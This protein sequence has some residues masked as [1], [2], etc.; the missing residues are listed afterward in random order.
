MPYSIHL[1]R[2]NE[3]SSFSLVRS[4]AMKFHLSKFTTKK[5]PNSSDQSQEDL[6]TQQPFA[7][8]K[9]FS[10][11]SLGVFLIASLVLVLSFSGNA[12]RTMLERSEIYS[13]MFAESLNRQV[14]YLF[15]LPTFVRYGRI[16]LSDPMQFKGLDLIVSDIIRGM[17]IK[18][19]T[20]FDSRENI[21]SYSTKAGLVGKKNIGGIEYKKALHGENSSVL[22]S[23][24]SMFSLLPGAEH[25]SCTLKTYVPFRQDRGGGGS[26]DIMGVVEVEQ[27]LSEDMT[28]L[29]SLQFKII[30]LSLVIMGIL[31][32]V[33]IALVIRADKIMEARAQER[34]ELERQLHESKRLASLGKMIA[35]VSHEIKN[36]LGIVRSTAEILG[37]RIGKVAPGNEHL[38]GIIV[39]ETSRLDRIV[40]EFLDFARPKEPT[41]TPSSLNGLIKR[42]VVFMESDLQSKNIQPVLELD[43]NLPEVLMDGE[44]IYQV[45][46]NTVFNAVHAMGDKGGGTLTIRT[47]PLG[48]GGA[49][50]AITDTGCG[51][52]EEKQAQIFTPFYT[53][54]NRG[55]GLGLAITKNIVSKHNGRI[56]VQSQEGEGTT[57]TVCLGD[58]IKT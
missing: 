24:G 20:I 9:Y 30:L 21:I 1:I 5:Q 40:R 6:S 31:F 19:V 48:I 44:Q 45:L 49:S 56:T 34:R 35:S 29:F 26:G 18:S 58:G 22:I 16:A 55:T 8:V 14:F 17:K 10:F 43:A 32:T 39:E 57:F 3:V 2:A 41:L 23:T 37:K 47:T 12:R 54:K 51:M 11:T 46:L 27:D 13:R 42:L 28:A 7:L 33:L 53:D 25:V 4:A 15:V 52:S 36:P 50:V 38:A